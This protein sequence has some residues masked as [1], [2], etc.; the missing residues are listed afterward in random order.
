MGAKHQSPISDQTTHVLQMC[1]KYTTPQYT[2]GTWPKACILRYPI[3]SAQ[4]K[5]LSDPKVLT[6]KQEGEKIPL[7]LHCK[8]GPFKA[9]YTVNIFLICESSHF[10]MQVTRNIVAGIRYN[11]YRGVRL[12]YFVVKYY[13]KL[14]DVLSKEILTRLQKFY[15]ERLF[16]FGRIKCVKL[17]NVCQK[18]TVCE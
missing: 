8:F 6:L 12:V 17:M 13:L 14:F 4:R 11:C 2:A 9:N 1:T 18:V 16:Y 5:R 7:R 15:C 3:P 10:E